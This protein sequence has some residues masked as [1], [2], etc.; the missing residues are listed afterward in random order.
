VR[1]V[2]AFL[3]Q[4]IKK[5]MS[6]VPSYL[7]SLEAALGSVPTQPASAPKLPTFLTAPQLASGLTT[8]NGGSTAGKLKFL[9]VGTHAHQFTGYSKVTYGFLKIL[10]KNPNLAVTHFGF[11]K[12]PQVP[13]NYRPYPPNVRVLDAAE[14]ERRA[15]PPGAPPQQGF[16][17]NVLPDTIRHEKPD[18]VLIYN[19]MA[20]VAR[21]LEEIRKSGIPRTFKIWLY[22]DQVYNCQLQGFIDIINRDADRVFAFTQYW[23]K[24]LKN[25]EVTR[26][27][28]VLGHGF[29]HD[30]FTTQPRLDVR[31]KLNLPLD[32]FIIS[33]LNRNQPRKR[34]DI[35]IMA[36]VE[37]IAKYPTKPIALLCVCDKGEKG[38]WWLFEVFT[39]ELKLRGLPIEQFQNRLMLTNTDM[40]FRDEDINMFYNLADIGISTADGEGWGLC[41]FE[42]MGVGVPQVVPDVGGFKEFCTRENSVIVKPKYRFYQPTAHSPVG[43]ESEACDPHDICLGIEEY[44]LDTEKRMR[45][46][47]AAKKTIATFT[48]EKATEMLTLRLNQEHEELERERK[49]A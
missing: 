1:K 41:N 22:V 5:K 40:N 29:E 8:S 27:I 4:N 44:L 6:G 3:L 48:W 26:P 34:Q 24:C 42:Q 12:N 43:G 17:Y 14:L 47:E 30:V 25:Q 35:L 18:V 49:H 10:A 2:K 36:F 31:K 20:V 15:T 9:F 16:G 45:H 7:Q 21:F 28:D 38:G 23:K 39:R 19:D 13:P 11:Q 32:A 33:C 46:G 37:L